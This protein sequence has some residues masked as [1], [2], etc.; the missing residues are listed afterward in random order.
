MEVDWRRFKQKHKKLG[1]KKPTIK[2]KWARATG[3]EAFQAGNARKKGKKIWVWFD[4]GREMEK[5]DIIELKQSGEESLSYV[6]KDQAKAMLRGKQGLQLSDT[7][8]AE[9]FGGN[10]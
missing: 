3:P 8:K 5:T 2:K 1:Y 10:V 7:A 6:G 9:T 4:K